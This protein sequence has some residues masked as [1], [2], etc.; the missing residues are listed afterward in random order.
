M[1]RRIHGRIEINNFKEQHKITNKIQGANSV[2][3]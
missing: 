3:I 1:D 2:I